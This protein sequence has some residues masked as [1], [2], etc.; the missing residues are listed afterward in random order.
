MI[1]VIKESFLITN[2]HISIATPL[3]LFSLISTMYLILSAGNGTLGL[4]ISIT[5]FLLMLGAFL[6][7]WFYMI[8]KS[9]TEND[10]N[11]EIS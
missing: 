2:N 9:V 8:K 5:L 10:S 6:S 4:I 11:N 3:I 1:K 7:G